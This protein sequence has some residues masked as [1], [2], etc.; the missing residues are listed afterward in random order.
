MSYTEDLRHCC[1]KAHVLDPSGPRPC[2]KGIDHLVEY[3]PAETARDEGS[4]RH[5]IGYPPGKE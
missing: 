2:Q 1:G 5:V 3:L 4:N